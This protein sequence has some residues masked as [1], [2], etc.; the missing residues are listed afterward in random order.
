MGVVMDDEVV[1]TGPAIPEVFAVSARYSSPASLSCWVSIPKSVRVCE[2]CG[3]KTPLPDPGAGVT[4]RILDGKS[5]ADVM[6]CHKNHD[7]RSGLVATHDAA[8]IMAESRVIEPSRDLFPIRSVDRACR[9]KA[10]LSFRP[11][12]Y[13]YVLPSAAARSS[14][15][16][17][18]T[19]IFACMSCLRLTPDAKS[20]LPRVSTDPDLQTD[21]PEYRREPVV[22]PP[23]P[24]ISLFSETPH[25]TRL[26]ARLPFLQLCREKKWKAL[27]F[28]VAELPSTLR[29]SWDG[30]PVHDKAWPPTQWTPPEPSA[31][32]SVE[33]WVAELIEARLE[34]RPEHGRERESLAGERVRLARNALIWIG[35]AAAAPLIAKLSHTDDGVRR[36]LADALQSLRITRKVPLPDDVEARIREILSGADSRD[37]A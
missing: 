16:E 30:I 20:K 24:G 36:V 14:K 37:G 35:A 7:G 13:L 17:S 29:T 5:K 11:R 2:S 32:K 3:L 4:V 19:D 8:A 33:E 27:E 31:G 28:N 9:N 25:Y 26:L 12:D 22:L 18:D 15:P 34:Q 10:S 23:L 6:Y 21:S 1:M